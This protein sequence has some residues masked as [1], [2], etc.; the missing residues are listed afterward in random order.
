MAPH[1]P[2]EHVGMEGSNGTFKSLYVPFSRE[3]TQ[4]E[5]E[6]GEAPKEP[7]T[8]TL[9]E[10]TYEPDAKQCYYCQ[11]H[12]TTHLLFHFSPKFSL[13]IC[14]GCARRSG[15]RLWMALQEFLKPFDYRQ[16][17]RE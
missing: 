10:V 11:P 13:R 9:P 12:H 2:T 14:Q 16:K 5:A 4:P 17:A 7:M 6:R 15:G 1:S 3:G 8:V